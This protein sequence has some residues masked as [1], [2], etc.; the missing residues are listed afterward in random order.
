MDGVFEPLTASLRPNNLLIRL[1]GGGKGSGAALLFL[2]LWLLG[3][4]TCL[5]FRKD[6]HIWALESERRDGR[7]SI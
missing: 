3:L 4:L 1:L 2:L 7:D 6:R 5:L